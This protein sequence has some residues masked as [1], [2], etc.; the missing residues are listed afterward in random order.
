MY[1][2]VLYVLFVLVL[3]SLVLSVLGLQNFTFFTGFV[4]LNIILVSGFIFNTLFAKIFNVQTNVESGLISCL[5]IFLIYSPSIKSEDLFS[6]IFVTFISL[7]SKFIFVI[8]KTHLFNPVAI[9]A[10]ISTIFINYPPL[11]WVSNKY[12]FVFILVG[13]LIILTKLKRFSVFFTFLLVSFLTTY[14]LSYP[15]TTNIIDFAY[16]FLVSYPIIFIGSVMLTEPIT[17]PQVKKFQIAYA[18][19]V[20]LIISTKFNMYNVIFSSPELALVIANLLFFTI[21]KRQ[22]YK[23]KLIKIKLLTN[24]IYEFIFLPS[25]QIKYKAGQYLECQINHKK[26]DSRGIR[27]YFT[28]SSSPYQKYI[29]FIFKLAD[30]SSSYKL[31]AINLNSNSVVYANSVGGDFTISNYSK[32]YVFIAGG[33]GIT[34]FISIINELIK[35]KQKV[36][37][38]LFYCCNNTQDFI[39]NT[40]FTKASNKIGLNYIK[41]LTNNSYT[42]DFKG[43]VGALNKKDIKQKVKNYTNCTFYISGPSKLV[44]YYSKLL[45]SLKVKQIKTDYFPGL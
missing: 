34:P 21:T 15:L 42:G 7:L 26:P 9:S 6:I 43:S 1:K 36:K 32:E 16:I 23:L 28:I 27:R 5:I 10:V 44:K 22:R 20:A 31:N 24:S 30:K 13:A 18:V 11:W 12:M 3:V 38:T 25:K 17:M 40:L 45:K 29:K 2:L 37:I 4:W 33:I 39:Y 8:N 41:V 19:L 35:N 14:L